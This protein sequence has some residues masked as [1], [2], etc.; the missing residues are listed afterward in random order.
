MIRNHV[1]ST[2]TAT[3]PNN[4]VFHASR[5]LEYGDS[6][7]SPSD[8][9]ISHATGAG[10]RPAATRGSSGLAR[11]LGIMA[12]M[13]VS[14]GLLPSQAQAQ[15]PRPVDLIEVSTGS[16][17]LVKSASI[18]TVNGDNII[19]PHECL[20]LFVNFQN[21][22]G[23]ALTGINGLLSLPLGFT[24]GSLTQNTSPYPDVANTLTTTNT[25]A[26]R[27]SIP[28][29]VEC[30]TR[31]PFTLDL[32]TNQGN[33]STTFTLFVGTIGDVANVCQ[34]VNNIAINDRA[35]PEFSP[36]TVT[37]ITGAVSKIRVKLFVDHP[38][39]SQ[40]D[41]LLQHPDG[42]IIILASRETAPG[43]AGANM[44]QDQPCTDNDDTIFD[45][46]AALGISQG[47]A[48][49][50]GTWRP[51][52]QL[53]LLAGK[54]ANGLWN[55][56]CIDRVRGKAGQIRCWC[57]EV[58]GFSCSAGAGECGVD[59]SVTKSDFPD[60]V[61][62]DCPLTYTITVTN[63]GTDTASSVTIQD[64]LPP[65]VDFVSASSGCTPIGGDVY[66]DVGSLAAGTSTSVTITVIPR[67]TG[68]LTNFTY[69]VSD[70]NE[71][72]LADNTTS[73]TTT[74]APDCNGNCVPDADDIA[75][76]ASQD[77]NGNGVP[78]DCDIRDGT[79]QDCNANAI[80]DECEA[81]CNGN[82]VPDDC[83]LASGTSQDTNLNG[84]PDEC[85][86]PVDL[87]V[88][89][90]AVPNPA[91]VD[92]PVTYTIVATNAGPG[93][94]TSVTVYDVGPVDFNVVSTDPPATGGFPGQ[95]E[96]DLGA[97]AAGQSTTI[98]VVGTWPTTGTKVN[99]AVVST[100]V[101]VDSN[102]TNNV[103]DASVLV[104][105]DCNANCVADSQDPDCNSNGVPDECD[106][107]SGTT[108]DC[109]SNGVPDE[110]DIAGGTSQD[111]NNNGRP[112]ECEP[113]CNANGV[114]D[115]C[116]VTTGGVPD[117]NSNGVPDECDISS[118][119]SEDCNRNGVPDECELTSE[120]DC[121]HSGILDE[122]ELTSA[123]DCDGNDVLDECEITSETDCNSNG[124]L[125]VCELAGTRVPA[126][127]ICA[128]A[129]A[130]A[131]GI[132]YIG[133]NAGAGTEGSASCSFG[134]DPT[135]PD[136]WYSYTP[137]VD[138]PVSVTLCGSNFDTVLSIWTAC[139]GEAGAEM[140]CNDDASCANAS[141]VQWQAS[142][143][144]TYLIR[145]AGWNGDT[146]IYVMRILGPAA[147]NPLDCNGNGILDEC[148]PDCNANGVPDDCDITTG[149]IPDCN[150]NGVPDECDISSGTSEDCNNNGIPDECETDCNA[151]GVPDDCDI[152]T[153]GAADCNSN[154]V[155]DECDISTGTSEDCNANG[156][157]DEC[158]RDCNNNGVPDDCDVTTGGAPDCNSNGVP[159]ECDISSGTS[160][161]CNANGIPDE[162]EADCNA[163]G[164]PDD[165][166]I[167]TGGAPDCNSNG[168]PDECDVSSGTSED[169]NA[170]GIPDECETDCN[171]NGVPD[172]CDITSGTSKDCNS[173]GVPDECDITS[174]TSEDCNSNGTPDECEL[175]SATD[176]NENRI[177]DEC[178][179]TSA[180]DCNGNGVLDECDIANGTSQDYNG[181]GVPDECEEDCNGNGVPDAV[182]I[183]SGTST[184]CNENGVPDECEITSKPDCNGNGVLDECE[185]TS[186]SDCN[187]NGI[188]DFCEIT[189]ETDCNNNGV[190]DECDVSSGG[191]Q[192]LWTEDFES[193]LDGWSATGLWRLAPNGDCLSVT[194]TI[195]TATQAAYNLGPLACNFD[196]GDNPTSGMLEMTTDVFVPVLAVG[197]ELKWF[198]FTETED[199]AE[200]DEW[201][202]EI[203]TD[204]GTTWSVLY[205]GNG[206][207]LPYWTEHMVD[208]ARTP[209][210]ACA[211]GSASTAWTVPRT[212][213]SAGTWTTS[214]SIADFSA[215]SDD[216]NNNGVPDECEPDCN[217][218]GV[219]DEC[220]ITSGTS[221]D[222]NTN[223]VPDECELTT[224]TDCNGNG[225]LDVCEVTTE[226]D[227]NANG[228]PDECE[229]TTETDC[230]ENGI[231]DECELTTETDCNG[232]GI[233]DEC[234][235]TT[236]TDCN[237]NGVLDACD[238]TSGTSQDCNENGVPDECETDCNS[239]GVPD[240]CDISSGTSA[241]CNQNG[242]PDECDIAS[243]ASDDCN[244]NGIPDECEGD[245]NG[246]GVADD[247]DIASGTS[248]DCNS[249][250]IPDECDVTTVTFTD[251]A[252]DDCGDAGFVQA[253]TVYNGDTT[254]A[255]NDGSASCGLSGSS[256]DVWFKYRPV[257]DG[258]LT[259][260]LCG[261]GYD[262][263]ASV[264]SD[265]PGTATASSAATTTSAACSRRLRC[266]CRRPTPT[267]SASPGSS[268]MRAH[269]RCCSTVR[270]RAP[271]AP[272]ATRT[273]FPTSAS[274]TATPTACP[275]S[276]TS[277]AAPARTATRTAC[278]TSATSPAARARTATRTACPTSASF[279]P[280]PTATE[281]ACSTSASSRPGPTAT[282]TA[283]STSASFRPRPTATRTAFSTSATSRAARAP[284]ATR[285][286]CPTSASCRPR[287]TAT[288]T[289]SSTSASFRPG[290][291]ATTTA[292]STSAS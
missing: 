123:T 262:T 63:N 130:A 187:G 209:A 10:L 92:C 82:G 84:I 256:R 42:T 222:C 181:N 11:V 201:V 102:L 163:N 213:G 120:T 208:M 2:S 170:N 249:N 85:E 280:G 141:E 52:Q 241:D 166:D 44:G 126:A 74:V 36:V 164:V 116:D 51:E 219:A 173:N 114:P 110:C 279:R 236:E 198:S 49:F 158:E 124:I 186:D 13:G 156:V 80:P 277:R 22:T 34:P 273:A 254:T 260:I 125:D 174:G 108:P 246:N 282:G 188:L 257:A 70:G 68:T 253:G 15:A 167:T 40:L 135:G 100:T 54:P 292:F 7:P 223:G 218:N 179:L 144:T 24:S 96:W 138:G 19:D 214:G 115:D 56:I 18:A 250:G 105:P 33:L 88:T 147:V 157:P 258:V 72:D 287:P 242:V 182:D 62:I 148:E 281:R 41:V 285:T 97:L 6:I 35:D 151:N 272:T 171:A 38:E 183:T 288:R 17:I 228:V 227:C 81:D 94:A 91:A 245:C 9:S 83:D 60:P 79:S 45:D 212:T 275:T 57:L 244:S 65:A 206:A 25:T 139:P 178:E 127:D 142:A 217:G 267:Q 113:D 160:Q 226:T 39:I 30:G 58:N 140:A 71:T 109:N 98:T 1:C 8:T 5:S 47:T 274:P 184:D 266:R 195:T 252:A 150:K 290:P 149:G 59:L 199:N 152:T 12:L 225:V 192:F 251:Q 205:N 235:I 159:D 165:C 190:L 238:I 175:S 207:D 216:C 3:K 237:G 121:N 16:T 75:G 278:P 180:A 66:C 232:N 189:S 119:T 284:T 117:C 106:I 221:Q 27:L 111:C 243:S 104:E 263:V 137:A 196:V 101:N 4:G 211:C 132:V 53:S 76:G 43:V 48:P 93:G 240:D 229:L 21:N 37:G 239:N 31:L 224:D 122:C 28:P 268:A 247:C 204:C 87:L 203:S 261:S 200:F 265:C 197:T 50:I 185:Q 194:E 270:R 46:S 14:L 161:D 168:V 131:P 176:C 172:D 99:D 215:K 67:A 233:L 291:T 61:A 69:A 269:S 220:D 169:C 95:I 73:I 271:S 143:G 86:E 286:A 210:R 136:V 264:H 129:P 255:T 230:N 193:G 26:Y 153:G 145:I 112:D 283:S 231:L 32:T 177:L 64:I 259:V 191:V 248:Q 90:T 234:E 146:G 118:G 77:C 78:D 276:A 128:D 155:P 29:G 23:A 55:L 107:T 162:C 20:D 89:K 133:T 289:A 134:G 103:A 202:V 154:G